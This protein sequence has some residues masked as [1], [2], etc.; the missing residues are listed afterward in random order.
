MSSEC[1]GPAS[2][3]QAQS[4]GNYIVQ[5]YETAVQSP[6][7]AVTDPRLSAVT[8]SYLDSRVVAKTKSLETQ[9]GFQA[10]HMMSETIKGFVAYLSATQ[11]TQLKANPSVALIEADRTTQASG[12]LVSS[13]AAPA[14]QTLPWNIS[15]IKG[16][17]SIFA[18]GDGYEPTST[19]G[20]KYIFLMDTGVAQLPDLSVVYSYNMLP[21]MPAQVTGD[22]NGHG[23]QVAGIIGARDNTSG[24][25][26]VAPSAP[27]ISMR[28]LNCSGTGTLGNL[29]KGIDF[30]TK[31]NPGRSIVNLS[32][33][34]SSP[35]V[36]STL[37][38]N[39]M[40]AAV[41]KG[42]VFSTEATHV[43]N[44]CAALPQ[45]VWNAGGV[46]AGAVDSTGA[47]PSFATVGRCQHTWVPAA[48]VQTFTTSGGLATVSGMGYAT[49]HLTGAIAIVLVR[50][51]TLTAAQIRSRISGAS[52]A[53][54][55]TS[56]AGDPIKLLHVGAGVL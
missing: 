12:A 4:A 7:G 50:Y 2:T 35:E 39:V 18:S 54:G 55:K 9:Y 13:G 37:L 3:A 24:L 19:L 52:F 45:A 23:T 36:Y 53:T 40:R 14:T 44:Y 20:S 33:T 28:V 46:L 26:G 8:W 47:E 1:G 27:V 48:N 29:I 51:P 21:D 10:S 41:A 16:Q 34:M 22:C 38:E 31:K 5:Y 15:Y 30:A 25:V 49:A 42:L 43:N 56:K 11:Y 6:V 32:L 17:L